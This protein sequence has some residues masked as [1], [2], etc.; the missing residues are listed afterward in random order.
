MHLFEIQEVEDGLDGPDFLPDL[1]ELATPTQPATAGPVNLEDMD[2]EPTPVLDGKLP[3]PGDGVIHIDDDSSDE[4]S[5]ASSV[6]SGKRCRASGSSS[7]P[8]GSNEP[9]EKRGCGEAS[10]GGGLRCRRRGAPPTMAG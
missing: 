2:D 9:G 6:V 1:P 8:A 4:D 7:R 3:G 10:T 5:T